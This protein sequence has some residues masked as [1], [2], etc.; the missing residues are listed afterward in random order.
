MARQ[1]LVSSLALARRTPLACARFAL[2]AGRAP[3]YPLERRG[4]AAAMALGLVVL[5]CS[6]VAPSLPCAALALAVVATAARRAS[7]RGGSV[8][9]SMPSLHAGWCLLSVY[10]VLCDQLA[11]LARGA[12]ETAV[13][14]G[15]ALGTSPSSA[16]LGLALAQGIWLLVAALLAA[17]TLAE[18]WSASLQASVLNLRS[19][20]RP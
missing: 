13:D 9:R 7:A 3:D 10:W 15:A 19:E 4:E 17:S 18:A 16:H 6:T 5:A 14:T 20:T 1:L 2:G 11:T 12:L 8:S